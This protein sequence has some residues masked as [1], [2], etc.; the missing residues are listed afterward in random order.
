MVKFDISS[1]SFQFYINC[2]DSLK[3]PTFAFGSLIIFR[4]FDD[5]PTN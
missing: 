2:A 1:V 5:G 4:Y 3:L